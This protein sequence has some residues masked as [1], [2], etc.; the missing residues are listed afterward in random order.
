MKGV[1]GR[2]G[3]QEKGKRKKNESRISRKPD[4]R[5]YKLHSVTVDLR[6]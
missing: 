2:R 5:M 4:P 6:S 3:I 1:L